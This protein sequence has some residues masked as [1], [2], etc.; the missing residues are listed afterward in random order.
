[1]NKNGPSLRSRRQFIGGS[2][3]MG[4]AALA[5]EASAEQ[6]NRSDEYLNE[7]LIRGGYVFTMDEDAGDL[8]VGDVHVRDGTI[9]A[10]APSLS[11][12]NAEAIDAT[13]M[14]VMP[15]FVDNTTL[16]N[17]MNTNGSAVT[18]TIH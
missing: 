11:A 9:V 10:V 13:G 2:A 4:F 8:A 1:M 17:S 16:V 3:A 18:V 7:Y 14:I 5:G 12:P 15:G 6:S